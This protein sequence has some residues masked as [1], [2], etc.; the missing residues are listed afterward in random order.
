[1]VSIQP[2][3]SRIDCFAPAFLLSA[4]VK[5]CET[6]S[7][8]RAPRQPPSGGGGD[9]N[10]GSRALIRDAHR[11]GR[12]RADGRGTA[13]GTLARRK[14]T[15]RERDSRLPQRPK[16]GTGLRRKERRTPAQKEPERSGRGGQGRQKPP[17]PPHTHFLLLL[18]GC[19]WCKVSGDHVPLR[20]KPRHSGP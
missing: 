8:L 19:R 7:T 1:M 12:R 17:Q 2:E 4:A 11:A 16:P 6:C 13:I 9:N 20:P 3:S 10:N 18:R 5:I 14:K 15:S